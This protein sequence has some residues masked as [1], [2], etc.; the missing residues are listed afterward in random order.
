MVALVH[1]LAHA[2]NKG[3][4]VRSLARGLN[5]GADSPFP[6]RDP[7]DRALLYNLQWKAK[8]G[9]SFNGGDAPKPGW[10]RS[11]RRP[12]EPLPRTS[13]RWTSSLR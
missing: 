9:G 12:R 5:R 7:T 1:F 8:A 13:Q 11:G 2:R 3:N 4:H 6:W 10:I